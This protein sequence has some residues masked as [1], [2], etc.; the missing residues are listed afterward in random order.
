MASNKVSCYYPNDGGK[1]LRGQAVITRV[2]RGHWIAECT[3]P[4]AQFEAVSERAIKD[5]V[6]VFYGCSRLRKVQ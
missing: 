5:K 6:R 3:G 4:Y 2:K 1:D